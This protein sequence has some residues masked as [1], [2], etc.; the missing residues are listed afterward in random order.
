MLWE[1]GVAGSVPHPSYIEFDLETGA[2]KHA[3]DRPERTQPPARLPHG[4]L[5]AVEHRDLAKD[6]GV[7]AL[8]VHGVA[9]QHV[10][11]IGE[12]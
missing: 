4:D 2:A 9:K 12:Q 1:I 10:A 8:V 3:W 6:V 5:A 7:P 11:A